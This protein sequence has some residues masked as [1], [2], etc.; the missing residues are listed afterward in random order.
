MRKR[1]LIA[2]PA[3]V[4][5]KASNGRDGGVVE[6]ALIQQEGGSD[7]ITNFGRHRLL[8]VLI[9][10]LALAAAVIGVASPDIYSGIVSAELIPGA[11]SQDL[12]SA[13]ASV[14]LLLLA[15]T[16]RDDRPKGQILGLGLIG[17]LFY[18]YGIYVI[19]RAYNGLYLLYM[20]I[21]TLTFWALVSA[22]ICLRPNTQAP[23]LPRALRITSASGALLQPVMFYP[24]WIAMLLPL[25]S[26]GNQIDSLYSIYIL[27]LCFIMPAFLLL[28]VLTYKAHPLGLLLLPAMYVLGFTLIFSLALGELVKPLWNLN[29]NTA[30]FSTSLALSLF[31]AALGAWHLARL[32]LRPASS[33]ALAARK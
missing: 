9:G 31:F 4:R 26:T 28:A 3:P 29:V 10:V 18:A 15:W 33:P 20:A 7:V 12:I 25:M 17:Y 24:L 32:H 1:R 14:A 8:W 5:T 16:S 6:W 23:D 13:V 27:D 11:Y 19:E 2:A 21:F 30:A 22:G